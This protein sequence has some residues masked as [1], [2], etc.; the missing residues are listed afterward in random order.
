MSGPL[1]SLF[2]SDDLSHFG[3]VEILFRKVGRGRSSY[4]KLAT[5]TAPRLAFLCQ[6]S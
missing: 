4:V 3:A 6:A 5:Y 2:F 1:L